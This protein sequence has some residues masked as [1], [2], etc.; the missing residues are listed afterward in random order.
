MN[1]KKESKLRKETV[2]QEKAR[3]ALETDRKRELDKVHPFD[4]VEEW[5]GQRW[6]I[7]PWTKEQV[8]DFQKKL[9]SAFGAENAIVLAWSGDESYWNEFYEDWHDNGLPRGSLKK[10]PILLWADV[11]VNEYDN[12]L[13][14][15][16][17]FVLLE[18]LHPSQYEQDWENSAWLEGGDG[19]KRRILSEKP[20]KAMYKVLKT[21]A[22]H[23]PTYQRNDEP[24]CCR[25][26]RQE[27]SR[28]CYGKYRPPSDEDLA[29]VRQIRENMDRAGVVQRNDAPRSEKIMADA[30]ASTAHFMKQAAFAK[31]RGVSEV[32]ASDPYPWLV[33][34]I[35]N[36]GITLTAT[37]IDECVKEGLRLAQEE[38]MR[39]LSI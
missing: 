29:Y 20:P 8:K 19:V 18:T 37:E 1:R 3:Q 25:A 33:D 7:C 35:K 15:P 21:I 16:P 12:F 30:Q 5:V 27:M 28:I 10:K 9:D 38:R 11:A 14:F 36:K 4:A 2:E 6:E 39:E 32:F 26:W 34:I 31:T 22:E 24:S 23:E 13:V 17:R